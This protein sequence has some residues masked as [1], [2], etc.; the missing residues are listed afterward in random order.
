MQISADLSDVDA[1]VPRTEPLKEMISVS[2]EN[3]KTKVRIN[4]SSLQVIQECKRKAG[5][6]LR[7]RWIAENESAATIFGSAVHKAL[8][9]F[10]SGAP[11]LRV[12]PEREQMELMSFG[13]PVAGEE[14]SL[15]LRAT[16]AFLERGKVLHS[17]PADDKRSLQA[18]VYM[19][20]HYFKDYLHDPFVAYID[21]NG[22][23]VERQFS[24][25]LHEDPTLIIEYFGTIDLAV[26]HVTTGQ[27]LIA[28]HKT[29]S[30]VGKEFYNRLKPNAQYTGY[31]LAAH[32]VFGLAP[33]GFLVNCLQVKSKPK[34]ARGTPP[35][36]PRQIT[37]RDEYDY[38][39]FTEAVYCA[40]QDYLRGYFR[41][42]WPMGHV[43]SCASYAG[44]Q[45]LAVCSAPHTLRENIL[46]SKFIK[47]DTNA[48]TE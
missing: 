46:K 28:D 15:L 16:R 14:D 12:L 5:L 33:E 37:T 19:L 22:P 23:F 8:E 30:V 3:G 44:C 36:F 32:R 35:H 25:I 24:F 1:V 6:L 47:G 11:E 31:L 39:E 10:Y 18:G 17:V 13:H 42:V 21:E 34:T 2:R 45:Y 27:L 9:V 41:E 48:K 43:S 26:K 7:D 4:S 20:W 38:R 40:V 29:S